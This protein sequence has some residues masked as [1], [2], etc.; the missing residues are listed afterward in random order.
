MHSE[1]GQT[2]LERFAAAG[3][4]ALP[5]PVELH[6]AFLWSEHRAVSKT[7]TVSLFGNLYEVDAALARRRVDLV[8]DPFDLTSIEVR[9]HSR[10]VGRAVP[11]RIC[12]HARPMTPT[13]ARAS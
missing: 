13:H 7:A 8:F 6:E 2:P 12:R 10:A 5:S 11:R 3:A 4:V 1:I 9:H